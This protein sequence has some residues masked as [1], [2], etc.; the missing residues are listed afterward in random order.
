MAIALSSKVS[1]GPTSLP[2]PR[3][4]PI[5]PEGGSGSDVVAPAQVG[6][7][8]TPSSRAVECRPLLLFLFFSGKKRRLLVMGERI[9]C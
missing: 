7:P 9:S 6:R 4:V 3:P 1:S 5:L 8:E 2:R